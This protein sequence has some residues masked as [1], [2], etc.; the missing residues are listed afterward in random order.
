MEVIGFS[1]EITRSPPGDAGEEKHTAV[2]NQ[3]TERQAACLVGGYGANGT[4]L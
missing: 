4:L 1:E 2:V 3:E